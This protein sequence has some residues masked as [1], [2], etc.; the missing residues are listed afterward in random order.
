MSLDLC[1]GETLAPVGESGCG[2]STIGKSLTNLIPRNGSI[3]IAGQ[4]IAG[5]SSARLRADGILPS[6][7]IPSP[8]QALDY[9]PAIEPLVDYGG[10]H[11][12]TAHQEVSGRG[13]R[14]LR[15]LSGQLTSPLSLKQ[16]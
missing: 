7:K 11:F 16:P 1:S 3:E 13:E 12:A 2:K 4:E 15:F 6:G 5:L 8:I 9:V 14:P 10:A